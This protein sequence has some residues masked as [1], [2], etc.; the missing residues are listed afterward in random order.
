MQNVAK[1]RQMIE[2]W[3]VDELLFQGCQA[4]DES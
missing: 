4:A 2:E 3:L 1:R